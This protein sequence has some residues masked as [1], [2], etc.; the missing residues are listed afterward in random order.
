MTVHLPNQ[1]PTV[2]ENDDTHVPPQANNITQLGRKVQNST[3]GNEKLTQL[4]AE[5]KNGVRD[6]KRHAKES[7]QLTPNLL[8]ISKLSIVS[9]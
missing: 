3:V 8:R 1:D 2:R 4:V 7:M 9:C 6:L 5:L